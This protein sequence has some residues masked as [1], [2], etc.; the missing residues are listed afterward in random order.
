L[1]KT[2]NL[3]VWSHN[4]WSIHTT[5]MTLKTLTECFSPSPPPPRQVLEFEL[6]ALC[7]LG[8]H[9]ITWMTPL[10]QLSTYEV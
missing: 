4:P 10:A 1:V 8:R 7:F 6:G 9:F 3:I 2:A 5:I